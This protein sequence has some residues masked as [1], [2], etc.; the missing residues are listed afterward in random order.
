MFNNMYR[1]LPQHLMSCSAPTIVLQA[2]NVMIHASTV[3]LQAHNVML[4]THNDPQDL[5]PRFKE[6]NAMLI[7]T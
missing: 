7:R 6:P 5:Q 4:Q 3:V 2:H 1:H